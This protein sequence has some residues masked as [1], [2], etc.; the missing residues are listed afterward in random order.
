MQNLA[1]LSLQNLIYGTGS[2]NGLQNLDSIGN[3]N[4]GD[5]N[6]TLNGNKVG[7][8]LKN[9]RGPNI[10]NH[11]DGDGNGNDN[12]NTS[13]LQN[14]MKISEPISVSDN[15]DKLGLGGFNL[16]LLL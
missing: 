14:L 12:M 6:G 9:L 1:I 5:A 7:I 8:F 10:G 2:S 4:H 16:G 3:N 15:R 13:K 11:N